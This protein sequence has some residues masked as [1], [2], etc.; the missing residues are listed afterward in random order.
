MRKREHQDEK[1]MYE[2]AQENKRM[3][4]PLS[5]ARQVS[6]RRYIRGVP[7]FTGCRDRGRGEVESSRVEVQ[8]FRLRCVFFSR[9]AT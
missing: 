2:I 9:E 5:K 8:K 1:L 7:F 3:S 4:E 6:T